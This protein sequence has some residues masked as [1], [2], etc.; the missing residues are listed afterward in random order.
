MLKITQAQ[1]DKHNQLNKRFDAGVTF[2]DGYE[3]VPEGEAQSIGATYG[4]L[5]VNIEPDGS[6]QT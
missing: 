4:R 6:S 2:P 1:L 5:Y 3:L